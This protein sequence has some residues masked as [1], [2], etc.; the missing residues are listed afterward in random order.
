MTNEF[1]RIPYEDTARAVV[2]GVPNLRKWVIE[3][4]PDASDSQLEK[5]FLN[6]AAA[7]HEG[8]E[9][10]LGFAVTSEHQNLRD[11]YI[12]EI[13]LYMMGARDTME[14]RDE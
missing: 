7:V 5:A 1:N 12:N 9:L 3:V 2:D 10:G 11:K 6:I 8:I 14:Y 13:A 4:F